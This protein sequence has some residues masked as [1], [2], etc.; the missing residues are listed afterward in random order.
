[1]NAGWETRRRR[2]RGD[3]WAIIRLGTAGAI[4][5]A[6]IDTRHFKGNA[7][8]ACSIEVALAARVEGGNEEA[9]LSAAGWKELLARTRVQGDTLHRFEAE[10]AA[11]GPATQRRLN[12]VPEGG[13]ARLRPFC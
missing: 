9:L 11:A 1:M 10:L 2:G 3:D 8:G 13:N 12:L 4:R 5:R 6:E 7:P